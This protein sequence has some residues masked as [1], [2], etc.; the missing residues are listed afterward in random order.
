MPLDLSTVNL[1]VQR[2]EPQ[3][4]CSSSRN[5][6]EVFSDSIRK[7]VEAQ[8]RTEK[9]TFRRLKHHIMGEVLTST[10]VV[11]RLQEAEEKKGGKRP[12]GSVR[13]AKKQKK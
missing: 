11:N 5:I 13:A 3:P 7:A 1:S 10:D 6:V 9:R 12:A 4:G 2:E 8:P